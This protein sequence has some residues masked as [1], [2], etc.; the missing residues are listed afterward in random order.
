MAKYPYRY[1]V[2][3]QYLGFRFHG[4]QKQEELKTVHEM[5]DKTMGFVLG[6]SDFK[7]MGS[8]RTDAMV[9]ASESALELFM[10]E[11][12]KDGFLEVFNSNLPPDIRGVTYLNIS[13]NDEFNILQSSLSKEYHYFFAF[14]EKAHPFSSP[15][16]YCELHNLDIELMK[17]GARLFQGT[18]FYGRY[19]T[20][21][22]PNT[23]FVRTIDL[24]IIES[25]TEF[26]ASFFPK[27]TYVFKVKSA[28]FMR[29][30]VRLMMGRL[31]QLGKGEISLS[32]IEQSLQ[33]S[34]QWKPLDSI[35]PASALQL[36]SIQFSKLI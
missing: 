14:G 19:C 33:P 11:P 27:E 15:F 12:L 8:S 17:E 6:H 3:I 36:S 10:N 5:V 29:N 22:G 32:E 25:N 23:S 20:K 1:L 16:I 24:S 21:P 9:S 30:Q 18:H 2:F 35:A 31:F 28:G 7:T 26:T 34:N 4:W 13:T